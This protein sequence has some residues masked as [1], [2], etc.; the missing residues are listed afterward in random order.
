[1]GVRAGDI[2]RLEHDRTGQLEV[3]LFP[4]GHG[5]TRSRDRNIVPASHAISE[6]LGTRGRDWDV[7]PAMLNA[8]QVDGKPVRAMSQTARSND[9]AGETGSGWNNNLALY[10]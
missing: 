3:N 8:G 5:I 9:P 2:F 1:M 10:R 4:S 6:N 7:V